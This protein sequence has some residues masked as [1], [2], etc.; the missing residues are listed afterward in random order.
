MLN[1]LHKSIYS[2]QMQYIEMDLDFSTRRKLLTGDS[3]NYKFA[4]LFPVIFFLPKKMSSEWNGI[5]P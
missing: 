5:I 3:L 1:F 2:F 4:R